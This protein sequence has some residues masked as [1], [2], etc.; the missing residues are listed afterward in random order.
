[1]SKTVEMK[2]LRPVCIGGQQ[3]ASNV[4]VRVSLLD[5]ADLLRVQRGVLVNEADMA[6]VV[7]AVKAETRRLCGGRHAGPQ[8]MPVTLPSSFRW[9]PPGS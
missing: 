3:F 9:F 2:T 6:G 7:E 1:M 8:T 4:K 5:A